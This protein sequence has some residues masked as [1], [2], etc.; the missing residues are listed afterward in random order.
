MRQLKLFLPFGMDLDGIT[1]AEQFPSHNF[2]V[3]HNVQLRLYLALV[4]TLPVQVLSGGEGLVVCILANYWDGH[5]SL[6]G[7]HCHEN[8]IWR[9]NFTHINSLYTTTL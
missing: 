7:W 8:P 2:K 1:Y 6:V 9:H 4:A 5:R 3:E